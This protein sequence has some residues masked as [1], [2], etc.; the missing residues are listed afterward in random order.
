M[1]GPRY[2]PSR[3]IHFPGKWLF[4]YWRAVRL[5]LWWIHIMHELHHSA[6]CKGT[7]SSTSDKMSRVNR[8]KNSRYIGH[9]NRSG[10]RFGPISRSPKIADQTFIENV[11]WCLVS[12]MARGFTCVQIWTLW[13]LKILSGVNIAWSVNNSFHI[14]CGC[15]T[16]CSKHHWQ[17]L[18]W[19]VKSSGLRT[20][21]RCKC[22][23]YSRTSCSILQ[24][25]LRW[26]PS[27]EDILRGIFPG[28]A[29]TWRRISYSCCTILA[30]RDLPPSITGMNVPLSRIFCAMRENVR[31]HGSRRF[32]NVSWY[33]RL[34]PC[35]LSLAR[36]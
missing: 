1:R 18:T 6:N 3:P 33:R 25:V 19:R 10:K 30:V 17:N 31:L 15:R 7:S 35:A 29:A 16:H 5:K 23:G 24:T 26:T 4:R 32:R 2:V 27:P 11:F 36:P 12:R 28:L 34:A 14:N 13:K 9:V 21:T 22:Y 8:S 20:C